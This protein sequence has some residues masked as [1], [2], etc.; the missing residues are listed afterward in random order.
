MALLGSFSIPLG[1]A[2]YAALDLAY[3]H[4]ALLLNNPEKAGGLTGLAGGLINDLTGISIPLPIL[5]FVYENPTEMEWFNY[6][7]SEYP[8]LNSSNI[9]NA[10]IRN[11]TSITLRAYRC[12]NDT[13]GVI[14]NIAANETL[15]NM[16]EGYTM[17]GGTFK[18]LS[19][20]GVF[21]NL[22]IESLKIV[23]AEDNQVGGT[24][25]EFTFKKLNIVE[26]GGN[27]IQKAIS[28]LSG[29]L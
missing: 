1:K 9:I 14:T 11:N 13:N 12:I 28:K 26:G 25:F 17:N 4:N 5:G 10:M 18:M 23:P 8:Y 24:G 3:R 19:L 21:D 27:L 16:L 2:G 15:Y 20:W 29:I 6:T 22:V 7:Y